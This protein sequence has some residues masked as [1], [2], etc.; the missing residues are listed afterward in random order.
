MRTCT[1]VVN[2]LKNLGGRGVITTNLVALEL[3]INNKKFIIKHDHN[4]IHPPHNPKT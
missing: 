2:I 1:V 3:N 4:E